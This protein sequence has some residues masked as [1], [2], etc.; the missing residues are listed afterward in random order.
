MRFIEST[1]SVTWD[2]H[3]QSLN[4]FLC[5]LHSSIQSPMFV[6][7]LSLFPQPSSLLCDKQ[8][9]GRWSE[10]ICRHMPQSEMMSSSQSMELPCA[11]RMIEEDGIEN[12]SD[13]TIQSVDIFTR[14]KKLNKMR[15]TDMLLRKKRGSVDDW[16]DKDCFSKQSILL[17]IRS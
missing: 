9:Y 5:V 7:S 16:I 14:R 15:M 3:L 10:I 8:Q 17:R 2:Y 11:C 13:S 1:W 12:F 4:I 6:Q